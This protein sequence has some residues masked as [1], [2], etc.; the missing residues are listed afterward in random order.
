MEQ[1]TTNI[2]IRIAPTIK[3]MVEELARADGRSVANYLEMLIKREH[4]RLQK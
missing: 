1:K 3:A 2:N 4:E